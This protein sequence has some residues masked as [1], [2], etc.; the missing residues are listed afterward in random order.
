MS[1]KESPTFVCGLCGY[2]TS[3]AF[4]IKKHHRVD[5]PNYVVHGNP[6]SRSYVLNLIQ[7]PQYNG[8]CTKYKDDIR[9]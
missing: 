7:D 5:H 6:K 9:S 1:T 4:Q 3:S 8:C 2:V